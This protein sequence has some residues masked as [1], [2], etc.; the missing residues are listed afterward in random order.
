MNYI[1]S[2][3]LSA[4]DN[5][6]LDSYL[7]QKC[8]DEYF[9]IYQWVKPTLSLGA[10]NNI[11][12]INLKYIQENNIDLVRRETGGGIVFHNEDLCF[13][14]ITNAKLK[15]KENYYVVKDI[16]E[17]VLNDLDLIVTKTHNINTK[18][19]I[20][21]HGSNNHEISIDNQKVIGIAQKLVKNRYLIQGSIQLKSTHI[22]CI[23]ND[24]HKKIVQYG[25]NNIKLHI[26][27]NKLYDHFNK[28]FKL[29]EM[30]DIQ[31]QCY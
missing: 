17:E 13:S 10:T 11:N 4:L 3:K 27:K 5:M 19:Q 12:E 28:K 7:T 14:F 2:D 1:Y 9:R 6:L 25:L 31:W 22:N 30:K 18:S 15:P 20:C 26:I 21:F 16:L 23:L 29:V 24:N 8:T